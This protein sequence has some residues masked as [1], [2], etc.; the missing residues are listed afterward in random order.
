M[1]LE[2]ARGTL[3][4]AIQ[5]IAQQAALARQA[6]EAQAQV[7]MEAM[8]SE[9]AAAA[10]LIETVENLGQLIDIRV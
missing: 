7:A 1:S 5:L 2:I 4:L 9:E 6:V 8:S 10:L 3:D